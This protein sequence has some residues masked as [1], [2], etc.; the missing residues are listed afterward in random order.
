MNIEYRT[1]HLCL[2]VLVPLL[3]ASSPRRID[4]F[5]FNRS[6]CGLR[7]SLLGHLINQQPP[8][9]RVVTV[10]KQVVESRR[11]ARLLAPGHW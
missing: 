4:D 5:C 9:Y 7:R 11:E 2:S 10:E 3:L 6:I 1:V 8:F